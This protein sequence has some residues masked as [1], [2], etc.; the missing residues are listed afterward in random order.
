MRTVLTFLAGVLSA[1]IVTAISLLATEHTRLQQVSVLGTTLHSSAAWGLA[2]ATALGFLLALFLLLPGRVERESQL[3]LFQAS[4]VRL[5]ASY[6]QLLAEHQHLMQTLLVPRT[7]GLP[8]PPSVP[9]VPRPSPS[10][11]TPIPV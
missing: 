3:H 6:R 10:E 8:A 11:V 5:L 2:A 9:S 1:A 4:Y 7:P